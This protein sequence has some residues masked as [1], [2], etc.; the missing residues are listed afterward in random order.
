MA[1]LDLS[2]S[3]KVGLSGNKRVCLRYF[4]ER[5]KVGNRLTSC[6]FKTGHKRVNAG[7]RIKQSY[8]KEMYQKLKGSI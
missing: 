7:C 5:G 8:N 3:G 2:G 6:H 1:V 4:I